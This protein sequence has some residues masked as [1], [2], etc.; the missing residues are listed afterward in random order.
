MAELE[1]ITII[2]SGAA[3]SG[4]MPGVR[5]SGEPRQFG[6][7]YPLQVGKVVRLG[8]VATESD[9]VVEDPMV[10]SYHANLE[11]DG[12]KLKVKERAVSPP[13][14]PR[15]PANPIWFNQEKKK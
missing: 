8:R 6:W 15:E 13:Q 1:A 5:N 11:W 3:T 10:S 14:Y 9:W 12:Q 4:S 2:E 7:R